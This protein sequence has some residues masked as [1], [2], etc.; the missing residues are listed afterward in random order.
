MS[1]CLLGVL[2]AAFQALY[3]TPESPYQA[4][5][6]VTRNKVS[7]AVTMPQSYQSKIKSIPGVQ[8]VMIAN[9]YGGKYI[10]DKP[11]HQFARFATEPD[12]LFTV[13]PEM[14]VADDQKKAFLHDR[15]ACVIGKELADKL[16]I[17]LGDRI[18]LIGDI[19]P[20]NLE[21]FVRGI[22]EAPIDNDVLYFDKAYVEEGLPERRKGNVGIFYIRANTTDDVPRI[23][24]NVD[25]MFA[26]SPQQTKTESESAFA[27]SFISFIGNVKAFLLIVGTAVTFTILL[28]C[29]NT[30]AMSVRERV[31][32]IGVLKVLGFTNG[33]VMGIILGEA[34][35]V[36]AL[37]GVIGTVLAG[38]VAYMFRQGP[39]Y[40]TQLHTLSIHPDV[41]LLCV[42]TAALIGLCSA[43][44]PAWN[45]SRIPIL[46]AL[47]N[48]D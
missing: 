40:G 34:L 13:R 43:F 36:A 27:L 41:A 48:T 42:A 15:R 2:M 26:N 22:Y 14:N 4:L 38:A 19:Y 10:D 5:R 1:L 44:I 23:E 29:A 47:R 45:A 11:E 8:E 3:I 16:K 7:L 31:R 25:A 37:G 35:I 20:G 39:N 9:W 32:E 12:K 46:Q 28:V 30:I 33:A 6:L 18:L 21:L 17:K 24:K